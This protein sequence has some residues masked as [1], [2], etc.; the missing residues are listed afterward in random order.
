M[1][2]NKDMEMKLIKKVT[3]V[4]VLVMIATIFIAIPMN[5]RAEPHQ[6]DKE[7]WENTT[8]TEDHYFANGYG[9]IIMVG[10]IT[11]DGDGYKIVG[12]GSGSGVLC[13]SKS[14]VTIKNLTIEGFSEGISMH[15]GNDNS[16]TGNY[17]S[18]NHIGIFISSPFSMVTNNIIAQNTHGVLVNYTDH[19]IYR[20]LLMNNDNQ[21]YDP[22]PASNSW[23]DGT[24]EVGNFWSNY[25]GLDNGDGGREAGDWIGDTEIPHEGV[26][27]Y[28][29]LDPSIPEA[30]G[31]LPHTG[32]WMWGRGGS[33]ADLSLIAP[34]DDEVSEFLNTI[35]KMAFWA[36]NPDWQS[37]EAHALVMVGLNPY[38]PIPEYEGDWIL[39]LTGGGTPVSATMAVSE[40]GRII[41]VTDF[42]DDLVEDQI[43]TKTKN[44][45]YIGDTAEVVDGDKSKKDLDAPTIHVSQPVP[46]QH[47][48]DDSVNVVGTA[49]DAS[50]VASITITLNEEEVPIT[51]TGSP[52]VVPFSTT[53]ENLEW[54]KNVIEIV[55]TDVESYSITVW[56]TIYKVAP[57][58]IESIDG[59]L[60]PVAMGTDFGISGSFSDE[61]EGDTHTA[62]WDWGDGEP[63]TEGEVTEPTPGEVGTVTGS[64]N[65]DKPGVY[66]VTLT[67][68]DSTGESDIF[69]WPQYIV[70]YDP[71]GSFV[72]GGGWINSPV[73]AYPADPELIGK[74]NFGFVAKHKKGS[75][76][77]TG[78]TEF[79]FHVGDLNFHSDVYEWLVIAHARAIFKGT[80]TINGGG[81]YMFMLTA[82]D[83][84]V[85]GGGGVDKFR[86][87]I[88]AEISE[89]IIYDNMPDAE[90][91]AELNEA[92][93]IGGGSIT[94][95]KKRK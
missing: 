61:S 18:D 62:T 19:N 43:L 28:P 91:D 53:F 57:P 52:E 7:I 12:G 92:T 9:F 15:G 14:D 1:L 40:G 93:E 30:Y 71:S 76:E 39:Q 46:S 75:M 47:I 44:V 55:A 8:L 10:G 36:P 26:D 85:T 51:P 42:S 4:L 72:T 94:I 79:Q 20:N 5:A 65:Y 54:G 45:H 13:I 50:G 77:P 24:N 2:K 35:G 70:I 27:M 73:D 84:E 32:W 31:P 16:I 11:L 25:F 66:S 83:G 88:W 64:Y 59:P 33:I 60:D 34:N 29:L 23:Y 37:P 56:R 69:K 22:L 21:I 86:I 87:K 67:V 3:P 95:H 68:E 80:G 63:P 38:D 74:A 82:V 81:S 90:D 17:I 41:S 6:E 58:V 89:D 48:Y 49:T 78:N